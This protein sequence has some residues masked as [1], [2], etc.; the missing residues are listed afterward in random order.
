[1]TDRRVHL[2]LPFHSRGA[3]GRAGHG[4]KVTTDPRAVSCLRCKRQPVAPQVRRQ[5]SEARDASGAP[6]HLARA[7]VELLALE[8]LLT[9]A[10]RPGLAAVVERALRLLEY[11]ELRL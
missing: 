8:P 5:W 1:M 4:S 7:R 9:A 6:E 3:C 10:G 11:L 2:S